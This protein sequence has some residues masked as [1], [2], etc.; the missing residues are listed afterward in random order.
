M[1]PIKTQPTTSPASSGVD[2]YHRNV[3]SKVSGYF[4]SDF[5]STLVLQ[6][7]QS[8]PVIRH[9]VAAIG[10]A[11]L[12]MQE[13]PR[14][15]LALQECTTAMRCLSTRIKTDATSPL[16]PLVACLLFTC[17]EFIRGNVDS[18]KVH[19]ISGFKIL[20]SI[21]HDHY[22][23]KQYYSGE[24]SSDGKV[25]EEYIVPVFARLNTLC[26]LFY[27]IF[28][29]I[30]SN[31]HES[32]TSFTNLTNARV[33]LFEILDQC[34]RFIQ[35]VAGKAH[36]LGIEPEDYVRQFHHLCELQLW[37]NQLKDLLLTTNETKQVD[38][39]NAVN[40]L[41]IQHRAIF[42][43][44]SICLS[45]EECIFDLHTADFAEIID[46]GSK[47][48][49]A[50]QP[51]SQLFSFEMQIIAP[52]YYTAVK[53]RIPHIRKQA[54]VLLRLAPRR[55]GLWS[56]HTAVRIAE[57]VIEIEENGHPSLGEDS[58]HF[59]RASNMVVPPEH[60]RIHN[61]NE[62]PGEFRHIY[63]EIVTSSPP[64]SEQI[65]VV[66]Q[67]KPWGLDKPWHVFEEYIKL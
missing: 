42:I 11:H 46:L 32:E 7:T 64:G 61:I 41:R 20:N 47:I 62:L 36:E 10:V 9:A 25:I 28:P 3:A 8:E 1:P 48:V 63:G 4:D 55:E 66:F 5:W 16:V 19:I 26:L 67:S 31:L 49:Q 57:R 12:D 60:A 15:T 23:I 40:L 2:F 37:L 17:L 13:G 54:L 43:W 45:G 30:R 50:D 53:C 24:L 29:P 18:A 58:N 34:L 44:I 39:E 14:N 27:E 65:K 6:L 59:Q 52:L 22:N 33:R 56:A 51:L 35:S 38:T 21:R